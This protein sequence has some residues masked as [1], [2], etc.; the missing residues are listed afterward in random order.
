[1]SDKQ[2]ELEIFEHYLEKKGVRRS[3]QRFK[4]L[5]IFLSSEHHISIAELYEQVKKLYPSIGAATV[6]RTM[7]L[8]SEAG[9]AE[10]LDFG[11]GLIRYEHKIGHAHHDHLICT[12]CGKFI[13][14]SDERLEKLQQ[15]LAERNDFTPLRHRLQ[16]F[17]ICGKCKKRK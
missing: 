2:I 10:E 6:Y 17:G 5:D 7:K 12:V 9:V 14:T 13:E 4:I 15:E 1:M 16:I 8:L 11:D 3:S